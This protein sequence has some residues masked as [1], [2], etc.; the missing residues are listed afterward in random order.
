MDGWMKF[1]IIIRFLIYS[2]HKFQLLM[3]NKQ[4][5]NSVIGNVIFSIFST[6]L[7]VTCVNKYQ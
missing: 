2:N 4:K 6:V 1:L 3:V 7:Q 5:T